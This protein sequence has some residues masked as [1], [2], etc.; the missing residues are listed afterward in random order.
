MVSYNLITKVIFT[1]RVTAIIN[2]FMEGFLERPDVKYGP[3]DG[4]QSDTS[5]HN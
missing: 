1:V 3:G 4:V 2:L 5:H